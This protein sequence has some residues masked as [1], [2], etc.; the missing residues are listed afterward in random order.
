MTEPTLSLEA[1]RQRIDALDNDIL[2]LISERAACAQQVAEIKAEHEP[3]AVFYRPE[4]EAQVLRRIMELN[5]GPLDSEEMARLFREIMSAC[6]ALEQPVKVAYLGPEG[7]FTQQAALKHFG[8]SAISLPMA[9]IDEVFRE[10]EA[11]AVNYGVVPVE[12]S[13]EGVINHTLD[14]FM[15]SGLRICGEVVLRIHHHLLVAETTRRDKVSRIY[16]HPQSFA[17]CRKWLDAHFPQA[18]RVPVSSNAEAARLVKTEWHSAAIAG[19]M[20]AKLYGLA[21]LAEKIEDRPDNS[22]RF[23]IIG[24]QDVPISGEDKTSLVV[25][26]RNQPGA[27]HGLLEPFHR[28]QIDMT[29]LETRP[30]RTGVWNYVFF[31]DFK[32]HRE[33]PRV[34]A[35]LEEVQL[36][37]AEVKVLGS[38]PVGVL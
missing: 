27:L 13:T 17:Q 36:R 26:M 12:N 23:L 24:N 35:M 3:G 34:A 32:G 1:L 11:G 25:A 7:T 14:S 16:S 19:D 33:E 38:Y 30:S 22:T 15:D 5:Q 31:I 2:R 28:H 20:A 4:R 29:R 18:E 21:K 8:E 37:A 10:V 6:L 9:A